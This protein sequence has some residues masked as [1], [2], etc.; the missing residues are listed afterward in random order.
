MQ[1]EGREGERQKI[2]YTLPCVWKTTKTV[3]KT[4]TAVMDFRQ[5]FFKSR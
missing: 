4:E 1:A 3:K 5:A 2:K